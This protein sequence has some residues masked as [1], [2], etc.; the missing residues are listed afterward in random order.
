ME[1]TAIAGFDF[2]KAQDKQEAHHAV[3]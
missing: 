2:P 1:K 3:Q